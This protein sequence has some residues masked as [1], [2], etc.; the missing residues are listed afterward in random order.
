M[1]FGNGANTHQPLNIE[2]AVCVVEELSPPTSNTFSYIRYAMVC[3]GG[4][5]KKKSRTKRDAC[6]TINTK[7]TRHT[8]SVAHI[9][10]Y[11]YTYV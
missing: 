1:D 11:L 8:N 9:V 6:A 7:Y 3:D 4:D 5:T 2:F 10:Y